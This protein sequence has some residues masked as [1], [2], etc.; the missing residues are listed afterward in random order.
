MGD[1]EGA[2]VRCEHLRR[3]VDRDGGLRHSCLAVFADDAAGQ[4]HAWA[5]RA[6]ELHGLPRQNAVVDHRVVGMNDDHAVHPLR[7]IRDAVVTFRIGLDQHLRAVSEDDDASAG[8][9]LAVPRD[10]AALHGCRGELDCAGIVIAEQS[11][12]IGGVSLRFDRD[13]EP[14]SG[15]SSR[16]RT[17]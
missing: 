2:V 9:G 11:D 15:A 5:Q 10:C 13:G 8:D 14:A 6:I 12:R 16:E 1:G 17:P 3:V 4:R 7:R